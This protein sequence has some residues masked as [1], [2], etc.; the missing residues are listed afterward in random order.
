M[1][2][3]SSL[4]FFSG[5]IKV[6]AISDMIGNFAR[7]LVFPYASLYI[8]ALG[9]DPAKIGFIGLLGLSAGLVVLPIAGYVTDHA[10]RIR[11]LVLSGFLSSLF[12]LLI[13][14]AQSWQAVAVATL[15]FGTVVFQFPAYASLIAD[16]LSPADRGRG[17][18]IMNTISSSLSIVAPFIA[19]II[20]DHYSANLGMRILY[21]VMLILYLIGTGIQYLF[22]QE[23]SPAQHQ[24]L[25]LSA[26]TDTLKQ[27]YQAAPMLLK[28]MTPTLRALAWVILLSFLA[29]GVASPFWVVYATEEIGLSATEWGTILLVEAIIR[30]AAFFAAGF[31]VDR[32]GRTRS[33]ML[34]LIIASIA[35]PLFVVLK[36][37]SG[38]LLVRSVIA[39]TFSIAIPACTA[40]MA[41]L[42]PRHLRG[43][44]MAA[45]GQGGM[46]IGPAGGGVGGPALG[47]LF[48]P[49]VMLA[50]LAGGYLYT[51]NP[52]LPWIFSLGTSLV[53]ILIT[54]CCIRDTSQ[55]EV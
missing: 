47:Y 24:P 6:F 50:S 51:L 46:M 39:V 49:F 41:D 37:F 38:I 53:S 55:A 27:A 11:L 52:T 12:L 28:Q 19:G 33:L 25:R 32:W 31:L 14:F 48:I 43:Q 16:S 13:I 36:S 21:T 23:N 34:A 2:R 4:S 29:N 8:L 35:T 18:G 10:D 9:G 40:L 54:A 26:L 5:N 30:L 44:M 45:I 3:R 42:V 20:V 1:K 7:S 15:L 22:L 17:I